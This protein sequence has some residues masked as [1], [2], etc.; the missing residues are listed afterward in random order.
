MQPSMTAIGQRVIGRRVL[1]T[2]GAGISSFSTVKEF[3]SS[4]E[5]H[6]QVGV[7]LYVLRDGVAMRLEVAPEPIVGSMIVTAQAVHSIPYETQ[8]A[9]VGPQEAL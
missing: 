3:I 9:I 1:P 4:G 2:E 6:G 8:P 7:E 5:S